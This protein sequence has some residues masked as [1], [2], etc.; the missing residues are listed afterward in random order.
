M[1]GPVG[2]ERQTRQGVWL[3]QAMRAAFWVALLAITALALTPGPALPPVLLGADKLKHI[4][5]F[6]VLAGLLRWGWPEL[7][8]W[9]GA[10]VLMAH[11]AF[12]E[13]VQGSP[14]LQR[15][16]SLADLVADAIGIALGFG[17]VWLVHRVRRT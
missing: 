15:E 16:M 14:V 8:L 3:R 5:A 6:A 10:A 4:A 13:I 11:G 12:L 1:S 7:R 2:V 9:I 17:A